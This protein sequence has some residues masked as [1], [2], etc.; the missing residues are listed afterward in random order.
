MCKTMG[1]ASVSYKDQGNVEYAKRNYLKAAA[2]YTQGLKADPQNA[3]LYR[4]VV[5]ISTCHQMS[6]WFTDRMPTSHSNRS[7]ALL[8]L[9]K[10]TKA[11]ADAEACINLRP[12]WDKGHYRK[13]L[14]SEAAGKTEEVGPAMHVVGNAGPVPSHSACACS[15]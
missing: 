3:T 14:A 1:D 4:C 11:L 7:A 12:D 15:Q 13:G 2:L 5:V 10:F 9:N 6:T 8:N